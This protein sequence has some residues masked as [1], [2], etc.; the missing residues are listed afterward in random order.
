MRR[1]D[2]RAVLDGQSERGRPLS[3]HALAWRL[4]GFDIKPD[5]SHSGDSRGYYKQD[6]VDGWKR[7]VTP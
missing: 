4:K 3:M 7:Y 5:Q 2:A 1:Y 6:F